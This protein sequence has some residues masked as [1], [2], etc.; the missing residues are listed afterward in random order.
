M[1]FVAETDLPAPGKAGPPFPLA[2]LIA[3]HCHQPV[4]KCGFFPITV[5]NVE[6][7]TKKFDF[8]ERVDHRRE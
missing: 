3:L 7:L 6:F 8:N 2:P 4:S 1:R 5:Q